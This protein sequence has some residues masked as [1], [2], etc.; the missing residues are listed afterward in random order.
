MVGPTLDIQRLVAY[1]LEKTKKEKKKIFIQ[2]LA[3][4]YHH[5]CENLPN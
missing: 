5:L 1:L 3:K 2:Y 4:E